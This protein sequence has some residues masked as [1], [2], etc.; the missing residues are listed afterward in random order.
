MAAWSTGSRLES[1]PCEIHT[2]VSDSLSQLSWSVFS[3]PNSLSQRISLRLLLFLSHSPSLPAFL[4]LYR[5]LSL[6]VSMSLSLAMYLS[7]LWPR[8]F[9]QA[10]WQ[11]N[12]K[13]LWFQQGE[14]SFQAMAS[15]TLQTCQS[16]WSPRRAPAADMY[17]TEREHVQNTSVKQESRTVNWAVSL[18]CYAS[19]PL[20][21]CKNSNIVS[22]FLFRYVSPSQLFP[23]FPM[24]FFS[25]VCCYSMH[26]CPTGLN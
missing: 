23:V 18:W 22:I 8:A 7:V 6:S 14:H 9:S 16:P 21:H 19:S 12:R 11:G 10:Q 5:S 13:L 15:T 17:S 25:S 4:P 20:K 1:I 26:V 2:E 3:L 24:A